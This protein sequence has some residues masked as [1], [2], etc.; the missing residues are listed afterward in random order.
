MTT[1]SLCDCVPVDG[2]PA[3]HVFGMN[4]P[5]IANLL[6]NWFLVAHPNGAAI[7]NNHMLTVLCSESMETKRGRQQELFDEEDEDGVP[8]CI[9]KLAVDKFENYAWK[10]LKDDFW[11]PIE[12][13]VSQ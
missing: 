9:R 12:G 10:R 4:L 7:A 2:L 5:I 6:G 1:E 8:E 3:H 13:G 11:V